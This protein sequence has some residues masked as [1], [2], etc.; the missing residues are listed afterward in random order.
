MSPVERNCVEQG[1]SKQAN[2]TGSESQSQ[3]QSQS[4]SAANDA[5]TNAQD[6]G[7]KSGYVPGDDAWTICKNLYTYL[8]GDM[9][10]EDQKRFRFDSEKR[11]EAADCKRC[12]ESRDYLLQYSAPPP[13]DVISIA[14][15]L[16]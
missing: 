12:E 8:K 1:T 3:S 9:S 4:Q 6:A 15:G 7:K 11:N 2:M 10:L 5:G 14:I 16:N 13:L